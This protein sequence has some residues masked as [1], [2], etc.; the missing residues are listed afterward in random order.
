MCSAGSPKK[1]PAFWGALAVV[2]RDY[3]HLHSHPM[4]SIPYIWDINTITHNYTS[5]TASVIFIF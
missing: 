2:R 5:V 4:S 1:P 3:L